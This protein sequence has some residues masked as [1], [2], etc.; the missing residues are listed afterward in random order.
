MIVAQAKIF[1]EQLNLQHACDYS[2]GWL[3][4]FKNRHGMSLHYVYGEKRGADSE[5]AA[6]YVNEF[7]QFVAKAKLSPEQ[8]YNAGE[9]ALY[10]RCMPRKTLATESEEAPTG[11][12]DSKGRVTVLGCSNAASTHWCKLMVI[13]KSVNPRAFKGVKSFP[14][15]YRGNKKG[16]ITTKLCLEWFERYFV[17]EARAHCNSVGLDPKCKIVLI[18]DNCSAHSKAELLVKDNVVGLYLPPNCISLIQPCDQGILRS[19]KCKY[20][21]AFMRHLLAAVNNGKH[22]SAFMKEVNLKDV[23]WTLAYAWDKVTPSTLKNG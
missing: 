21:A 3:H 2:Q 12:K 7:A 6:K 23:I 4:K 14:V 17:H 19:L 22:V 9:T 8:V 1:H 13:G 16:W 10:W 5:A 11:G 18:L 15:I 20:R